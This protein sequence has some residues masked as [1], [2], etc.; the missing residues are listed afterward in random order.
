MFENQIHV[1]FFY[2]FHLSTSADAD[3]PL[4]KKAKLE[5]GDLSGGLQDLTRA[6][7]TEVSSNGVQ[8]LTK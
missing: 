4:A 1:H 5:S 3:E 8:R 6:E 2:L 7:V